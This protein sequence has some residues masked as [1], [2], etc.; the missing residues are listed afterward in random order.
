[1]LEYKPSLALLPVLSIFKCDKNN[2]LDDFLFSCFSKLLAKVEAKSNWVSTPML[3]R[4]ET[5]GNALFD[6]I[7]LSCNLGTHI[8]L[9]DAEVEETEKHEKSAV[10]INLS[11]HIIQDSAEP[12]PDSALPDTPMHRNQ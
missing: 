1:M 8:V 4:M 2:V 12:S 10:D 6:M 11:K 5:G 3:S 9:G 7:S